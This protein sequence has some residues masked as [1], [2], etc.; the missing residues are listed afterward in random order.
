MAAVEMGVF[1]AVGRHGLLEAEAATKLGLKPRPARG[2]FD[3]CVAVGL[4]ARDGDRIRSTPGAAKY[5]ASDSEYSFRNYVLDERWCWPAWG[6]L[7]EALRNDAPPLPQDDDGYHVFPEEFLLDFLHGHSLAMGDVLA[8][9][10]SLDGVG[11]IMDIGGGSGAVS[12]ALCRAN[13][14][15]HAVVVDR[16]AVLAKTVEHVAKAGL[17]GRIRTH[18]ANVFTDELP[19]SCDGAVIANVLHDFSPERA[20]EIL[21]R[22]AAALPAG[23]KLVVMEIAPDDDRSGPV[24]PAV[25]TVTMI[26][27]TEG[28]VAHTRAELKA[29]IEA[30]GFDVERDVTLGERYVTTAIEARKR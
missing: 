2:L 11:Q 22:V 12:I 26:V 19:T 24:L 30:A 17:S 28:G 9:A 5:L 21:S 4:L 8:K 7:E 18:P 29:M 25:F 16:D 13:P 6:R 20:G 1:D 15:M 10:I 23:G 3:T 14:S 27:N